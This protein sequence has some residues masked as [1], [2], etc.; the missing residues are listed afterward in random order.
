MSPLNKF[1]SSILTENNLPPSNELLQLSAQILQEAKQWEMIQPK[2]MQLL[3]QES[4]PVNYPHATFSSEN[5]ST[6]QA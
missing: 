1:S 3:Y 6:N 2:L 5:L 4:I